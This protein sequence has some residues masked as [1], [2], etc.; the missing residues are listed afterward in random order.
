MFYLHFTHYYFTHYNYANYTILF[1]S[2]SVSISSLEESTFSYDTFTLNCTSTNSPATTVTWTRN[3]ATVT[4][5]TYQLTQLLRDGV[6]ATYDN[7]LV[8]DG[9]PD[10][11]TGTY[12]CSV[13]NRISVP[14]QASVTFEGERQFIPLQNSVLQPMLQSCVNLLAHIYY[15]DIYD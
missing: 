7:L 2:V 14:V 8:V 13:A 9:E 4:G 3:G 15:N 10:E 12:T 1:I 11:I 5:S 6:T